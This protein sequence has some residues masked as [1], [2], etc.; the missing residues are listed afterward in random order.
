MPVARGPDINARSALL[1]GVLGVAVAILLV[2]AVLVLAGS[3]GSVEVRL[4][5]RDFRDLSTARISAE[6]ADRGPIIFS[7]VAGGSRDIILQHLGADPETGWLAFD[8]RRPDDPRDCFFRW[9]PDTL[10]FVNT[11]DGE[12]VVDGSGTGLTH[13]PV[14]VVDGDV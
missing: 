11:C 6:I 7:D 3:G 10:D 1:V 12:D 2:V 4:G 8:V 14:E 9:R 13:Y 5:D